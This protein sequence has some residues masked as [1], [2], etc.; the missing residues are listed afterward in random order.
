MRHLVYNVNSSHKELIER[1]D[2]REFNEELLEAW[3]QL[4]STIN[5]ERIVSQMPFNEALICRI[6]YQNRSNKITATDL[7]TITKMQKSQMNRTLTSMESK[8]LVSR[9]RST[10]DKRKIYVTLNEDQ[11]KLYE[12]EHQRILKIVDTLIERVGVEKAHQVLDLFRLIAR[13]AKEEIE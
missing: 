9:V 11:I 8:D 1:V 6:L 2:M 10:Q 13:I 4:T 3:L 5:N 7:C 12:D